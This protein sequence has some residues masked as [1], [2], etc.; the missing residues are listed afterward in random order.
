MVIFLTPRLGYFGI[1]IAEPLVWAV[2]VIPLIV[3]TF[4]DP[5]YRGEDEETPEAA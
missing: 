3:Q 2:M 4:R 5:R 1:I